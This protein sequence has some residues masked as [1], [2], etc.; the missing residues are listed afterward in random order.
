MKTSPLIARVLLAL[1]FVCCTWTVK[2]DPITLT[3]NNTLSGQLGQTLLFQ[4]ILNNLG[5]PAVFL[6]SISFTAA[7][8]LAV[9]TSAFFQ[10]PSLL[11]PGQTTGLVNLF[12]VTIGPLPIGSYL[13]SITILGGANSNSQNSLLTRDFQ[14]VVVPEPGTLL[15]LGSGLLSASLLRRRKQGRR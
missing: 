2:A 8:G 1:A 11:A 9:N 5:A 4:G 10:L 7:S 13:G 3:M 12:A 14:I 15:L 6:N